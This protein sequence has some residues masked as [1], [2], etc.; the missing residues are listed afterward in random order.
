MELGP[1]EESCAQS[2]LPSSS[3]VLVVAALAP[4]APRRRADAGSPPVPR[5]HALHDGG[6]TV[7]QQ[8]RGQR[9]PLDRSSAPGQSTAAV[10]SDVVFRG[11][12]CS[13]RASTSAAGLGPGSGGL[14]FGLFVPLSHQGLDQLAARD[15][16]LTTG[17]AVLARRP[18]GGIPKA[19]SQA[20][21]QRAGPPGRRRAPEGQLSRGERLVQSGSG[22]GFFTR[23]PPSD[24]DPAGDRA[25]S[26][27]QRSCRADAR[28]RASGRWRQRARRACRRRFC[29]AARRAGARPRCRIETPR[30]CAAFTACTTVL[31]PWVTVPASGSDAVGRLAARRAAY[32]EGADAVFDDYAVRWRRSP[33]EFRPRSRPW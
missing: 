20:R 6:G 7:G 13:R 22:V 1:E 28:D 9:Q 30:P 32:A 10:G 33:D 31:G 2:R 15:R 29:A 19:R 14:V 17:C 5:L 3:L 8:R 4:G 24:R 11:R 12:D 16:L 23:R 25:P 26:P 18:R 21:S 27:P